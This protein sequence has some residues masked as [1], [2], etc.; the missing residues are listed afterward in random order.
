MG[1]KLIT[2][3]HDRISALEAALAKA[4]GETSTQPHP[5]LSSTYV[6][7]S[8]DKK[9]RLAESASSTPVDE[10]AV[11][12][13]FGTLTIGQDGHAR[14]VG[15]FAGSEYLRSR[16]GGTDEVRD[17]MTPPM[18]AIGMPLMGLPMG[19]GMGGGVD[20]EAL[21]SELPEWRTEGEALV[22]QYWDNVGWM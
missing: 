18:T 8:R 21:R 7:P 12:S 20:I 5:L 4:H 10:D 16:P 22:K 1:R 13:A 14:F 19:V 17:A 2:Q 3:L 15:S 9:P 11:H 6:Y